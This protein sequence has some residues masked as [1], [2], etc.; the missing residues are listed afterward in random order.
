MGEQKAGPLF[1]VSLVMN[2]TYPSGSSCGQVA[3][4]LLCQANV[5]GERQRGGREASQCALKTTLRSCMLIS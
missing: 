2:C 1:A 4:V 3:S 5:W